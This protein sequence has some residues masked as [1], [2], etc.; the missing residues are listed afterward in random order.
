MNLLRP[1]LKTPSMP[2]I[3]TTTAIVEASV[4]EFEGE[5]NLRGHCSR[6]KASSSERP[7]W[8]RSDNLFICTVKSPY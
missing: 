7:D 8:V 4:Q 1:M 2:Y 3:Q 5:F 6:P